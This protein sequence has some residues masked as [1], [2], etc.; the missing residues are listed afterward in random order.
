MTFLSI[1]DI[2]QCILFFVGEIDFP[3]TWNNILP[4]TQA[5]NRNFVSQGTSFNQRVGRRISAKSA[6]IELQFGFVSGQ[7][8][9]AARTYPLYATLRVIHGWVKEGVHQLPEL[10]TD[11]PH[12]YSEIPFSKYKVLSDR[13]YTRK[14]QPAVTGSVASVPGEI[15]V[16]APFKIKK[17]WLPN[18]NKITFSD[19]LTDVSYV[20]WTPF[21]YI[22]NPHHGTSANN[23]QLEFKFIKRTFAFKD[24]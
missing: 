23:L 13:T 19:S 14:A 18:G 12:M 8:P 7:I 4:G 17:T 24:A 10:L 6:T 5:L 1:R 15:A 9:T 20:G 21:L 11:V 22:L 16:Y 3:T 2:N